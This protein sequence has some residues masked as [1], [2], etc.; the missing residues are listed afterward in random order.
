MIKLKIKSDEEEEEI[1]ELWLEKNGEDILVKSKKDNMTLTEFRIK[2]DKS[3]NKI[4]SGHLDYKK[5]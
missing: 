3:W 5:R 2:E 4:L 1:L